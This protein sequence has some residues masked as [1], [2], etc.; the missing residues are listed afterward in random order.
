MLIIPPLGRRMVTAWQSSFWIFQIMQW[1]I[2]PPGCLQHNREVFRT[3]DAGSS[4]TQVYNFQMTHGGNQIY[5][6]SAGALY[7]GGY[8][9]IA[10]STDNGASW[11][12]VTNGLDYSWYIGVCGD[13]NYLYTASSGTNRPFWTSPESDGL[14]WTP[15]QGGAQ[16]F[17]TDPFEMFFDSTNRIMYSANWEGLFALK[18]LGSTPVEHAIASKSL[19]VNDPAWNHATVILNGR[20][21][22]RDAKVL[23]DCSINVYDVKGNLLCRAPLD[24]D[25][26]V[27]IDSRFVGQQAVVVTS[28]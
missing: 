16:T 18:V 12:Q 20:L 15:Y 9:Y 4:W 25:G 1:A 26:N 7:S 22:L 10:R 17:T 27:K 11:Q 13:G 8:Q 24:K 28:R 14:T 19:D 23:H 5:C 3:T 2:I 6:S 21:N